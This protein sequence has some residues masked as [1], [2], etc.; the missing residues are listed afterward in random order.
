[1]VILNNSKLRNASGLNDLYHVLDTYHLEISRP[2]PNIV[3]TVRKTAEHVA[4]TSRP[5]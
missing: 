4:R 5:Y 3:N 1:M 2:L